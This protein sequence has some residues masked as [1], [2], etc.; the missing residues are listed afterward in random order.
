MASTEDELQRIV[1]TLKNVTIKYNLKISVNK[2]MAMAMKVKMNVSTKI[3]VD[4]NINKQ[5]ISFNC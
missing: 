5:V 4:S 1:C 2:K 3:V